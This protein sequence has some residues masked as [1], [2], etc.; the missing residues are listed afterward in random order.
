[1]TVEEMH[2]VAAPLLEVIRRYCREAVRECMPVRRESQTMIGID[3]VRVPTKGEPPIPRLALRVR[4]AA[5]ALGISERTLWGWTNR[6]DV[7]HIRIGTVILYPVDSLRDWLK[8]QAQ[9][10]AASDVSNE[11]P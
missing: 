5:K 6:G 2:A 10:A 4:D 8:Q 1:M 11:R 7:P 3:T 9:R